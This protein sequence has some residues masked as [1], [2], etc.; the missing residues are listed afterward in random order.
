MRL[1]ES[2]TRNF[3]KAIWDITGKGNNV[4]FVFEHPGRG[5]VPGEL[6]RGR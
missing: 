2:Q 3:G 4:D 1:D 5:D 6:V